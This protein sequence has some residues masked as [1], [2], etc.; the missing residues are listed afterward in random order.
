M[1]RGE[2]EGGIEW[3]GREDLNLRPQ[4][5]ERCALTRLRYAPLI[6]II[7]GFSLN[8]K[9]GVFVKGSVKGYTPSEFDI[10]FFREE[11]TEEELKRGE[12]HDK[13][14]FIS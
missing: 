6:D 12:A 9:P 4:R 8:C 1:G 10:A 2:E 7:G 3:S 13:K 5:P 11:N 14:M